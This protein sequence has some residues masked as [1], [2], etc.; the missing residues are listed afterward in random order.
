MAED[1]NTA[2]SM[3]SMLT[4]NYTFSNWQLHESVPAHLLFVL[5]GICL[6]FRLH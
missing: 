4:L 3:A 2:F 1:N 5:C 6:N